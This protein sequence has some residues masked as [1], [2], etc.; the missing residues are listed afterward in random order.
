MCDRL[1]FLGDSKS[2]CIVFICFI[3]HDI[4]S[5]EINLRFPYQADFLHNQTGQNKNINILRKKRAFKLK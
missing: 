1:Y 2:M 3:V 5:F 4:I